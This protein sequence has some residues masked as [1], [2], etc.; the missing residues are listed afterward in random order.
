MLPWERRWSWPGLN[1]VLV[2]Q[3]FVSV[4]VA[5]STGFNGQQDERIVCTD[6]K[7]RTYQVKMAGD[8]EHMQ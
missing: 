4:G 5:S 6:I 7:C 1:V 2:L 8:D 3:G